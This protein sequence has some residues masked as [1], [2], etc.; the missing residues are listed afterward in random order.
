MKI[1]D[2]ELQESG[3]VDA[4]V[5]GKTPSNEASVGEF[6]YYRLTGPKG[7]DVE[8]AYV[9]WANGERDDQV[10]RAKEPAI[11]SHLEGRRRLALMRL[12][13]G[14][15]YAVL[16]QARVKSEAPNEWSGLFKASKDELDA[17]AQLDVYSLL[18]ESGAI[19]V[20][21]KES[22][23]GISD[24]QDDWPTAVFSRE[25]MLSPVVAFSVTRILPLIAGHHRSARCI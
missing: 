15:Y 17:G 18:L 10:T 19:G 13:R 5:E 11:L 25:D 23:T 12:Q 22:V 9:T 16:R 20:G 3:R 8:L 6:Q 4:N 2:H 21:P 1:G 24:R 14:E 7:L